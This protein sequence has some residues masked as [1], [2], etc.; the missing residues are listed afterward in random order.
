MVSH[1]TPPA[2]RHCA[3]GRRPAGRRPVRRC[4]VYGQ[5]VP[6]FGV[7]CAGRPPAAAGSPRPVG[8][9]D[10]IAVLA[11]AKG[12]GRH[13]AQHHTNRKRRPHAAAEPCAEVPRSSAQAVCRQPRSPPCES[14]PRDACLQARA[15]P[16]DLRRQW[17]SAAPGSHPAA[18]APASAAQKARAAPCSTAR[19]R[20]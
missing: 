15:S 7:P 17:P 3:R 10:L 9:R 6:L 4:S 8:C 1:R 5:H 14:C 13:G 2:A 12:T 11:I 20:P 16:R 18:K 19:P